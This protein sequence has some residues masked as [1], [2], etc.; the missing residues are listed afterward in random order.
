MSPGNHPAVSSAK[1]V[2]D[3]AS[4]SDFCRRWRVTRFSLFG[5]ILRDDFGP[6]SDIDVLVTFE[7]AAAWNLFDLMTMREE[8]EVRFGRRVDLVEESALKNP[9]RRHSILS[10]RKVIHAA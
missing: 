9:F 1:P 4:V 7:L 5:S 6:D 3:S 2:I 8:L 10:T